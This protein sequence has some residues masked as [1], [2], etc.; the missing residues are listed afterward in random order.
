LL[1]GATLNSFLLEFDAK[2]LCFFD[3]A[4]QLFKQGRYVRWD[5][6]PHS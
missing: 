2:G 1:Y 6:R 5:A 3:V 4:V